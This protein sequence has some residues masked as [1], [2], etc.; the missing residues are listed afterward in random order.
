MPWI[1]LH[2]GIVEP[3]YLV[4]S[5]HDTESGDVHEALKFLKHLAG[6]PPVAREF[7]DR[8]SPGFE[9][10]TCPPR[11]ALTL[12]LRSRAGS[13]RD[14][15]RFA[16]G[17]RGRTAMRARA[18]APRKCGRFGE[19]RTAAYGCVAPFRRMGKTRP[20]PDGREA[21]KAGCRPTGSTLRPVT[22]HAWH[23]KHPGR[24][25][26]LVS[27][28]NVGLHWPQQTRRQERVTNNPGSKYQKGDQCIS[29]S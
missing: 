27:C 15:P 14:L 23:V 21:A 20:V 17:D 28:A 29:S 2:A 22:E 19:S 5:R 6:S 4:L 8:D 24:S 11:Y 10:R 16:L 9:C 13:R 25:S 12:H 3:V 26:I 1:E 7:K 18:S